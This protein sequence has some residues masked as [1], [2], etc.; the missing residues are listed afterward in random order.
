MSELPAVFSDP[1]INK[2]QTDLD[3]LRGELE[4]LELK[5][6]P[7]YP[8]VVT[9]KLDLATLDTTM[10]ARPFGWL[11]KEQSAKGKAM[12]LRP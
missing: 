10:I 4:K 11:R 3:E 8:G 12:P 6:G 9:A 5:Y 1:K 2:L 7:E